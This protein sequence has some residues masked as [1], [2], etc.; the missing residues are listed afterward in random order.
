MR[1]GSSQLGLSVVLPAWVGGDV[2]DHSTFSTNRHGRFRDRDLLR[3]LF[4]TVVRRC[5]EEGSAGGEGFAVDGRLIQA[6][7]TVRRGSTA[8]RAC[9]RE[10]RAV[11]LQSTYPAYLDI[12]FTDEVG[13]GTATIDR[14]A[15][16]SGVDT[17][18]DA[19]PSSRLRT[20]VALLYRSHAYPPK[21]Q[22]YPLAHA[23]SANLGVSALQRGASFGG[24]TIEMQLQGHRY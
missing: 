14:R 23:R 18:G 20:D 3:H 5:I 8:T 1:R 15:G 10:L 17:W 24:E 21:I 22:H 13:I 19:S 12:Y 16:E 9:H 2:P 6:D 11:R 4:E 7:A